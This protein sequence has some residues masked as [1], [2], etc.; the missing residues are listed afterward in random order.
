M[1][2]LSAIVLVLAS[3]G[4]LAPALVPAASLPPSQPSVVAVPRVSFA[5]DP[6]TASGNCAGSA[7]LLAT[8]RAAGWL[9]VPPVYVD[10]FPAVDASGGWSTTFAMPPIPSTISLLCTHGPVS[11]SAAVLI[12][13]S[14]GLIP[15]NAQRDGSGV[16]VTIPNVISPERL[17]AFTA[18]G[19][20]VPISI[21]NN[22]VR[23][24]LQPHGIPVRIVII[25][26]E[27]LGEN[28]M[29]L[30]NSRVQGWSVDVGAI[31]D[32]AAT[33]GLAPAQRLSVLID[34]PRPAVV[35]G[36]VAPRIL[37]HQ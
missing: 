14:D 12:S 30:Q 8:G 7:H 11:D 6:V 3:L 23:V 10:E 2:A 16:V 5:G 1:R 19:R 9:D 26:I 22:S 17:A 32:G 37:T 35:R 36:G 29:A 21:L 13:P 34:L 27:S 25:G 31:T 24:R 15:L 33:S 20:S 28:A 18:T 4:L